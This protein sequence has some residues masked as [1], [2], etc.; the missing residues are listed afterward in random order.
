MSGLCRKIYISNKV[1]RRKGK[2]R[3]LYIYEAG[4]GTLISLTNNNVFIINA[5]VIDES[6][7]DDLSN[8][9]SDV[10]EREHLG[11]PMDNYNVGQFFYGEEK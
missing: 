6:V 11:Y 5:D 3:N 1:L 9:L 8:G 2:M 4:T 7:L 10:P